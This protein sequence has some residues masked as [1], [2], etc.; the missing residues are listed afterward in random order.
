MSTFVTFY[1]K[2]V[3]SDLEFLAKT[4]NQLG[5]QMCALKPLT[6]FKYLEQTFLPQRTALYYS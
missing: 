1:V 5:K 6:F 4:S 3:H 2:E